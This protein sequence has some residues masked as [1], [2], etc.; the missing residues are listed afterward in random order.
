M[1]AGIEVTGN[2]LR[3]NDSVEYGVCGVQVDARGGRYVWHDSKAAGHTGTQ[4]HRV[5]LDR[6]WRH[7][8]ERVRDEEMSNEIPASEIHGLNPYRALAHAIRTHTDWH[9]LS[10]QYVLAMDNSTTEAT[11]EQILTE[12]AHAGITNLALL[13]RP[14][15]ACMYCLEQAANASQQL[16]EG[17][18][19]LF[20]D[21]GSLRPECCVMEVKRWESGSQ[22]VPRRS[23][24]QWQDILLDDPLVFQ[25]RQS[26]Y[27]NLA[28]MT[29]TNSHYWEAGPFAADIAQFIHTQKPQGTWYPSALGFRPVNLDEQMIQKAFEITRTASKIDNIIQKVKELAE[30]NRCNYVRWIA[31]SLLLDQVQLPPNHKLLNEMAVVRGCQLYAEALEKG[32]PTYYDRLSELAI[33]SEGRDDTGILRFDWNV[34]IPGTELAGGSTYQLPAPIHKFQIDPKYVSD[35]EIPFSLRNKTEY[36]RTRNIF[37][38]IEYIPD[39]IIPL[40]ITAEIKPANGRARIWIKPRNEDSDVRI[41]GSKGYLSLNWAKMTPI[42]AYPNTYPV[43]GRYWDTN[44]AKAKEMRDT[45]DLFLANPHWTLI[46]PVP[47]RGHAIPFWNLLEPWSENFASW[48]NHEDNASRGMFGVEDLP[49]DNSIRARLVNKIMADPLGAFQK[50]KI[51]SYL[52]AYTTPNFIQE[53]RNMYR[54]FKI[55]GELGTSWILAY[56]P[57]RIFSKKDDFVLYCEALLNGLG[58]VVD[59]A[60]LRAYIW[61]FFRCL[62]YHDDTNRTEPKLIYEILKLFCLKVPFL[63]D[64]KARQYFLFSILYALRIRAYHES[65]FSPDEKIFDTIKAAVNAIA[66]TPFPTVVLD[67]IMPGHLNDMLLRFMDREATPQ[68]HRIMS[69]ITSV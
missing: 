57:G 3:I 19:F 61:S 38:E 20:V 22:L 46:S 41:F 60:L 26:L 15:A 59:T 55:D 35:L 62:C 24:F 14:V 64:K 28:D 31:P 33:W 34:L 67:V 66:H 37:S 40:S 32:L 48:G 45:L 42:Q 6:I 16:N 8:M 18:R 65:A 68:D 1:S 2:G 56:V 36:Q 39:G 63:N 9:H 4:D 43:R 51:L 54:N 21:L 53:M 23:R 7:I 50:K 29:K 27:A 12:A 17:M 58:P 30:H 69:V 49:L 44:E 10:G 52:F 5:S 13:W 11:Q 47:F 25:L